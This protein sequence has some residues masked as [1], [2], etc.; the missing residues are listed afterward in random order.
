[1]KSRRM[2][3][4]SLCNHKWSAL[5]RIL[6]QLYYLVVSDN[7]QIG[8]SFQETEVT[9]SLKYSPLDFDLLGYDVVWPGQLSITQKTTIWTLTQIQN[10]KPHKVFPSYTRYFRN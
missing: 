7:G 1:M 2:Q 6:A 5:F 8:P 9:R 4:D 10:L 3:S